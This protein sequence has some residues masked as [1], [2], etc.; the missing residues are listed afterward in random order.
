M[1]KELKTYLSLISQNI[2]DLEKEFGVSKIA[3]FGSTARGD[4]TKKSD[5]DVIVELNKEIGL[6]AFIKLENHLRKILGKKVDLA[7]KASLKPAIKKSILKEA[8]YA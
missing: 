3:I 8:I 2:K 1:T 5:I 4:S 6:F 7:T